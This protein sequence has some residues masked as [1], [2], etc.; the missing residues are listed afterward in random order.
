MRPASLTPSPR[1]S[2]TARLRAIALDP[3]VRRSAARVAW[4]DLLPLLVVSVLVHHWWPRE[5]VDLFLGLSR[6]LHP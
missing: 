2:T 4:T 5:T 1:R 3:A 6:V